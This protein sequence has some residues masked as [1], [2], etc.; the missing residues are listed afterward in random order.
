MS[1]GCKQILS[2]FTGHKKQKAL[3]KT[4]E[5]YMPDKRTQNLAETKKDHVTI[6]RIG[7]NNS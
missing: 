6:R 4:G 5:K 3:T 7:Y 2:P 1:D